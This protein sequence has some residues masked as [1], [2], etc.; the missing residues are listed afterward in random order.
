MSSDAP[1]NDTSN[2]ISSHGAIGQFLKNKLHNSRWKPA[3]FVLVFAV[4]GCYFVWYSSAATPVVATVQAERMTLPVHASIISDSEASGGKAVQLNRK[5]GSLTGS[6]NLPSNV[7]SMS[8]VAHGVKCQRSWPIMTVD[9]NGSSAIPSAFVNSGGWSDYSVSRS[10]ASGTY[11]LSVTDTAKNSCS[12]LDVDEIIFYGPVAVTPAPTISFSAS[13]TSITAGASSTLTWSSANTTSCTASGAWSGTQPTSGSV[14]TGALNTNTAYNL[15]C[16]N[17]GSSLSASVTVNV[18]SAPT[19]STV[20]GAGFATMALNSGQQNYLGS[21]SPY[22][23]VILQDTMSGS[24]PAIRAANPNT[25]ILMYQN[26][27]FIENDC[28]TQTDS[29]V[30]TC[31]ANSGNQ[32]WYLEQN[33]APLQACDYPG[34]Y[35]AD[36]GN[37]SYQQAWL[38]G[39]ASS[40]KK[41]G[42]DGV[43][44]DDTN[45]HPG[46]CEDGSLQ[47]YTDVQYGDAMLSFLK[48]QYAGLKSDGLLVV[49]N[50]SAD[51]WTTSEESIEEQMAPYTNA[52]FQE[53]FMNWD[54]STPT[55][56]SGS[57]WSAVMQ[58]M[59]NVSKVTSYY[60]NTYD[61]SFNAQTMDYGRASFL[62]GWNGDTTSA[63]QFYINNS[64]TTS[65]YN[66]IWAAS[67]GTPT[68]T[69]Y[70]LSNGAWR[71]D[72]TG[73]I[74][75]VNP[76]ASATAT[77]S[78]GGT[79]TNTANSSKVTSV[80][81]GPT[82]GAILSNN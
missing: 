82:T 29:P 60:A 49:P 28:T 80:T 26:S 54:A 12:S 61:S 42:F 64:N 43:F 59:I 76:S 2:K 17:A 40:A 51:A 81:L 71:R 13:P 48:Y 63:S 62:L 79:Y 74:V 70:E 14:S 67:V 39:A 47:K 9:I 69:Y 27:A 77:V 66:P 45:T 38:A 57:Q 25:K 19:L 5:S 11:N 37:T 22:T 10:L 20:K 18:T 72:F 53:M 33:G 16:S 73:G 50:I 7:T 24:I 31:Q 36:I 75:L 41:E 6:V 56:F 52:V 8:V 1:F 58:Q 44:L 78:L 30:N 4:I 32:Q 15:S 46:H 34:K 35:W 65:S 55:L 21:T 68:N 23:Y 3:L